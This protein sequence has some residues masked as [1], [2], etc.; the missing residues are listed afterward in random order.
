MLNLNSH[1]KIVRH[2]VAVAAGTTDIEP[3]NGVDCAG[4]DGVRF[5]VAFGSIVA[6]AVTSIKAQASSD[7]GVADG[8]SDLE[9]TSIT[10]ADDDDNGVAVLEVVAPQKRY[11]RCVV[12]RGTQNAVVD[13]IIAEVYGA[14]GQMPVTQDSTVIGAETHAS[15]DEGTA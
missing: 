9:G 8:W 4:F 13:A 14:Q 15:P 10:V 11:V 7:D 12:D 2:S 1:C 5:L 3:S 6:G